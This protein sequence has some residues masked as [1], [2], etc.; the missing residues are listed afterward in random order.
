MTSLTFHILGAPVA[1]GRPRISTRSGYPIAYTPQKTRA[2]EAD[3]RSQ[4]ISQLP[5]AFRPLEGPVI[6]AIRFYMQRPKSLK[7]SITYPCNK[8]GDLD[9]YIKSV[10]DAMN[11]VVFYDDCQVVFLSASKEYG[12]PGITIVVDE[13]DKPDEPQPVQAPQPQATLLH[14]TQPEQ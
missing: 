10:F 6:V 4:I 12:T 3:L 11:T 2:A 14:S 5:V 1:K 8:R 7:K 13:P 9:N